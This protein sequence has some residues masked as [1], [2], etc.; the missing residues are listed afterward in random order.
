MLENNN[1]KNVQV[2]KLNLGAGA[3]HI[4]I[5]KKIR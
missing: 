2:T 1:F 5:K 3:I 4:G